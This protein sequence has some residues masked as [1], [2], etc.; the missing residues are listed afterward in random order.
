[1]ALMLPPKD[2]TLDKNFFQNG[3]LASKYIQN[4]DGIKGFYKGL[5][6]ATA[7]AALGCYIFFG[8]LRY[9]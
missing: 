2:L 9:F 6:A 1:M 3:C 7:K 8:T 5:V 4:T